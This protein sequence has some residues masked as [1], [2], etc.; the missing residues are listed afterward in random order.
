MAEGGTASRRAAAE[1][2]YTV[3]EKRRTLDDAVS[4]VDTYSEL[5]GAD[6]GFA[7]A[8]AS[9]ALR[10]LGRINLA[11]Q[12]LLDRPLEAASPP[13]RSLLQIGAAQIWLL[14]TPVHAAVGETVEAAKQWPMA[15]RGSGFLNAVLRKL[16]DVKTSFDDLPPDAI[17]PD[18]FRHA[19]FAQ[20]D[21]HTVERLAETQRAVPAFH[22]TSKG[23][24]GSALAAQVDGTWLTG[25]SVA[26]SSADIPSVPGYTEGEWWVQDAAA[27]LPADLLQVSGG[28]TVVDLCAAP[29]GKTLQLASTGANVFAVDRSKTRLKRVE[30]NLAR[31]GLS[32]AVS[33][34]ASK[35]E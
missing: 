14:G 21:K 23:G 12:P 8:M 13:I 10:D 29:G 18:W 15:R 1:L 22:L 3:V 5:K 20:F 26:L 24:D 16:P 4:N 35:G 32:L 2:L 6:R 7:R 17:W 11:L 30:E 34:V 27:A 25:P 19:L 33:L 31:T 28:D 9:A